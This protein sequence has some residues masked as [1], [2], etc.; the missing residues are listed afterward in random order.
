MY[1]KHERYEITYD[2]DACNNLT[3]E[4]RGDWGELKQY[5]NDLKEAGC[6]NIDANYIGEYDPDDD[7]P[8]T[9]DGED[10]LF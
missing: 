3:E 6:Y 2:C 4:F 9:R 10:Y 5:I 1:G 7:Y 8:I